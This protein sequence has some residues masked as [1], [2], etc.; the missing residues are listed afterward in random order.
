MIVAS[1]MLPATA[2]RIVGF[3][4]SLTAIGMGET[5]HVEGVRR[6][7]LPDGEARVGTRAG[8]GSGAV[9]HAPLPLPTTLA[10]GP[11]L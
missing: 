6:P 4:G 8:P 11:T 7:A 10:H 5:G 1:R 2:A 9:L 3:E